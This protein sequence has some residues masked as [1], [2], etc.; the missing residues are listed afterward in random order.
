MMNTAEKVA[1]VIAEM[2]KANTQPA[3]YHAVINAY[4]DR[5]EA[6][7]EREREVLMSQPRTWKVR[8]T[9]AQGQGGMG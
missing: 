2:R 3:F 1:E 4:A 9:R 6:A 7:W 5:L 8:G